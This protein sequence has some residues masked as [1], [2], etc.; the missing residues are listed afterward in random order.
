MVHY[1]THKIYN[2]KLTKL[3]TQFLFKWYLNIGGKWCLQWFN[4]SLTL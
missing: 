4:Q 2:N 1:L 3:Y